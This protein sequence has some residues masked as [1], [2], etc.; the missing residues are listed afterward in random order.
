M[1][2]VIAIA[3]V[4]MLAACTAQPDINVTT[5][6]SQQTGISVSGTGEVTGTPDT[7]QVELGVSVR[8]D[9][10]DQAA[11]T[12]AAK[13]EALIASL[14]ASGVERPD[15]TTTNYSIWPEYDYSGNKETLVGYRVTNT[16]RVKIRDIDSAGAVLDDAVAAGGDDVVV[17]GLQFSI[18]DDAALVEAARQAAWDDALA[19]ATQ[20]AQLSGRTLGEAVSIVETVSSTPPPVYYEGDAFAASERTAIEPG[21]SSV[22][23]SL[24]VQFA[25]ES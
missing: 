23:I 10:V 25:F 24:Q 5:G 17:S 18:E 8:G 11:A 4:L 22:V 16:V 13:A 14:V 20:L 1:K 2:S 21:T 9:T 6:E 3:A 7:V 15:I 19:K 12:A